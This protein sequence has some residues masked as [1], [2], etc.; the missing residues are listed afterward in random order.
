LS[1]SSFKIVFRQELILTP[2]GQLL[3]T[4]YIEKHA[5]GIIDRL[6]RIVR[7]LV[8]LVDR[9]HSN[10]FSYFDTVYIWVMKRYKKKELATLA[11]LKV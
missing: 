1:H 3:R 2:L 8:Y 5:V 6:G 9:E 4:S 7:I 11:Q 10:C